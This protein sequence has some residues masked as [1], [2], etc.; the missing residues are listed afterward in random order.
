[1]QENLTAT[2]F[3]IQKFSIHDGPGIRSTVFFAGCPL[4]CL[5]CSNPESQNCN[6]AA[7]IA[8]GDAK[9]A[10]R[11]WT[12]DEVL[13]EVLKDKPFYDESGGGI[14]LSGGE[15]LQQH[16]FALALLHRAREHGLRCALETTGFAAPEIFA[17]VSEAADL[18]LF[19]VKHF[20]SAVHEQKTG[21]PNGQI[22]QNLRYAVRQGR[23]VIARIPVIPKFNFSFDAA[24]GLSALLTESGV[25]EVHLLPFHQF[26]EKKYEQLGLPY[27]MQGVKQ[28]HPEQLQAYRNVFTDAGLRCTII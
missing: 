21:V 13:T 4:H 1:M 14:T 11:Q 22:V 2:I 16:E 9:L 26:G 7:A 3:N 17:Q 18:L 6:R 8:T 28:L 23:Q 20:D 15:V 25:H 10:G 19:D 27:A 12:L 24:R 5:W